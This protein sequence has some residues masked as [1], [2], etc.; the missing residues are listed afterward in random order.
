MSQS[1]TNR[2]VIRFHLHQMKVLEPDFNELPEQEFDWCQ[3]VYGK[4]E[5]LLPTDAP[6]PLGNGTIMSMP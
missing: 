1:I 4:V 2:M 5:E 3:S 6:K